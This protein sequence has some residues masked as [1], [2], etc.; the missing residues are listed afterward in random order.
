[1]IEEGNKALSL[2]AYREYMQDFRCAEAPGRIEFLGNHIDYNGGKVLG[3]AINGIVCALVRSRKEQTIRLFSE[4][5]ENDIV[6]T[7]LR[8]FSP[9]KGSESWANYPLGVLWVLKEAGLAPHSGFELTLTTDLPLAAGLSS[10]AAVELASALAL[11]QLGGHELCKSDLARLCRRAEN[12]FVG[13]PCGIL[14]Q[15]VSAYGQKDHLVL[16]DCEKENFSTVPLPQNTCLWIFDTGIKH[17]LVDS[18]Y[19]TRHSEC[20]QAL[21]LLKKGEPALPCLAAASE[22]L[23][24]STDLPEPLSKR[25]LHVVEEN[26]RVNL[27]I[28]LL[29]DGAPPKEIGQLLF[30]SHTSSRDLF[31]NSCPELDFL[32]NDLRGHPGVLGARLTGGGF[33]GAVLAWTEHEFSQ[34]EAKLT[35]TAFRRTFGCDPKIHRFEASQGA[36]ITDPLEKLDHRF[37]AN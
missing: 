36:G 34:T 16:I 5:F 25:A 33:G 2:R 21:K 11:L 29:L 19:S 10:S 4:S 8:N 30:A 24:T 18:L 17:D 22:E 13:L 14:D 15:G 31:E 20:S 7:S 9:R 26:A 37:S 3:A 35:A 6:E 27:A 23:L 28:D 12:E 1:M 32:V